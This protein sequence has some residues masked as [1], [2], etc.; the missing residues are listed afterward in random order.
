LTGE[1]RVASSDG[2]AVA[3][4]GEDIA[5][6]FAFDDHPR[7]PLIVRLPSLTPFYAKLAAC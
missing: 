4:I 6:T 7:Q 1:R 5:S 3:P 2:R